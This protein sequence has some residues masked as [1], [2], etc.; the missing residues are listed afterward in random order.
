MKQFAPILILLFLGTA[1]SSKAKVGLDPLGINSIQEQEEAAPL[2]KEDLEQQIEEKKAHLS[3][4]HEQ[5]FH[6]LY[7]G[8]IQ[9]LESQIFDLEAQKA[10]LMHEN[11]NKVKEEL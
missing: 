5:V 10:E 7:S 6:Q 2:T 4:L 1:C 3:L 9:E 11:P 8:H